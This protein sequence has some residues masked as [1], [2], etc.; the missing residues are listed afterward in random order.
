[1]NQGDVLLLGLMGTTIQVGYYSTAK[2][3]AYSVLS[4]TD[5]LTSSIFPQFS[6]LAAE[7]AYTR[8][9]T[10][11]NTTTRLLLPVAIAILAMGF[12]LREEIIQFLFGVEFNGSAMPFFILLISAIQGSLFF[13]SVPLMQSLGLIRKRL[14]IHIFAVVLGGIVAV[15]LINQ[16]QASG[17]AIGLM[18]ANLF[19]TAM[20]ILMSLSRMNSKIVNESPS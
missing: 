3:L 18:C 10:M 19:I 12:F 5:P 14:L 4:I 20:F 13:W 16:Y 9:Q 15:S 1:M 7:K 17:V 11:L 2:K 6:H 8:I